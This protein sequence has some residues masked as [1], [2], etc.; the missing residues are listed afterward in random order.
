MTMMLSLTLPR[1]GVL[2]RMLATRTLCSNSSNNIKSASDGSVRR[3]PHYKH[4]N[5]LVEVTLPDTDEQ[6]ADWAAQNASVSS[7]SP[8]VLGMDVE[9]RPAWR[10]GV[11]NKVAL[12]QLGTPKSVLLVQ[13]NRFKDGFPKALSSILKSEKI[14]KCGVGVHD[15]LKLLTTDYGV[16]YS[17]FQEIGTAARR[18]LQQQR[19]QDHQQQL[20][21]RT[22]FGLQS[23]AKLFLD[24]D[25]PKPKRVRMGNW[26]AR[27]L[28]DEQIVYAA[29][30]ALVSRDIY[31]AIEAQGGFDAK[32]VHRLLTTD[33]TTRLLHC[34]AREQ[35]RQLFFIGSESHQMMRVLSQRLM[36]ADD[37]WLADP[38]KSTT[39]SLS[40]N[41]AHTWT[42]KGALIVLLSRF[43]VTAQFI[44]QKISHNPPLCKVVIVVNNKTL[45]SATGRAKLEATDNACKLVVSELHA[46]Q[47]AF[48]A[49][50]GSPASL[51]AIYAGR[52]PLPPPFASFLED[53]N[54]FLQQ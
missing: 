53:K 41:V 26:E 25:V 3:I 35:L 34:S 36:D 37:A 20:Q 1:G 51:L 11:H 8:V 15:D 40:S 54:L 17:T 44:H 45:G 19:Q 23:M 5:T 48:V 14:L 27:V 9:W 24:V 32:E 30:D 22:T 6:I 38:T 49:Q 42:W 10:A 46:L 43:G 12:V 39:A 31:D 47:R 50:Q 16:A 21:D 52:E 33:S 29:Y 2:S 13:L 4:S 18:L 7:S 28:T